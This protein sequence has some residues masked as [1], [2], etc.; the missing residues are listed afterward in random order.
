MATI[1]IAQAIQAIRSEIVTAVKA[2]E[3]EAIKFDLGPIEL[4]FQVEISE[5]KGGT[6]GASAGFNVGVV[7][8]EVS[9]EGELKR[10]K[11]T[12]HTVKLTLKP[13]TTQGGSVQVSQTG[14]NKP[15]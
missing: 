5:E 7:A 11:A 10:S 12:T 2:G 1:P 14:A 9:A 3:N 15:R 8:L 6:G 13:V 4:E